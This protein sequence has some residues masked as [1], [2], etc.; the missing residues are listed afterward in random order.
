MCVCVYVYVTDS[1]IDT[2]RDNLRT[3]EALGRTPEEA[4]EDKAKARV[5]A[6]STPIVA[7]SPGFTPLHVLEN[8]TCRTC[9]VQ[10]F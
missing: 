10:T 9:P 4:E 8:R 1:S 6:A 7:P 5:R 3:E 2:E